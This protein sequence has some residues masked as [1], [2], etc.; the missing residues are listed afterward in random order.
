MVTGHY[1]DNV[2]R[3]LTSSASGTTY[4]S[5]NP[6]LVTVSPEGVLTAVAEG[7]TF[8]T[9]RNQEASSFIVTNLTRNSYALGVSKT[10][11]GTVTST[12][13]G[14][15]CGATCAATFKEGT[16][17]TLTAT[18]AS[19]STFAGWSGACAGTGGCT[20]T[21]DAAK[22][23]TANFNSPPAALTVTKAGTGTG[24][25]TSDPAGI[26]CGATC[27]ATFAA[28][29]NV[30]LAATPASDSTFGGWSG[31][32]C[33]GKS[34]CTVATD[35]AQTVTATFTAPHTLTVSKAGTGAGAI[36]SNPAG[37]IDCG[38]RCSFR[39]TSAL[40]LTLVATPASGSTFAGWSGACSG[41]GDCTVSTATDQSVTATFNT[42]TPGTFALTVNKGGTADGTVTGSGINC[43]ATCVANFASGASV[44]LTATPASG[45]IFSYWTGACSGSNT[46]CTVTMDAAKIV[47]AFFFDPTYRVTLS[48]AGT[49]S[50][51][52]N[53]G[54]S[55]VCNNTCSTTT[56]YGSKGSSFTF[57]ATPASNSTFAGWSGACVGTGNCTVVTDAPKSVTA[58]FEPVSSRYTLTVNITGTGSGTVT[59]GAGVNCN[60]AA[61]T[62]DLGPV[63]GEV[64]FFLS[65]TPASGST[66]AG[67]SGGC[68]GTDKCHVF[69]TV[70]A[71]SVSVT[72][73]FNAGATLPGD[74]NGDN[75]ADALDVVAVINA[76]L[77]LSSLPAADVNGDGT[78]NALDVVYVINK[79]LGL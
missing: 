58:T 18:P 29:T 7:S 12:P 67:W 33:A 50:G 49:G 24:V 10:G 40:T 79:V 48:K 17:V 64:D 36:T 74:V 15:D 35:T 55:V 27:S 22:S 8:V 72:A 59:G 61:C 21:L 43:G 14:I 9:A 62:Y 47:T 54:G 6:E 26:N 38:A 41:T 66:F 25:V 75:R 71:P 57:S 52:V 45:F 56:L 39:T 28:D 46:S 2:D 37:F 3:D 20:V 4:S 16:S 11:A 51:A 69:F 5:A 44:T 34:T 30:T 53:I 1:S 77:G 13:A 78:V 42:T 31:G 60:S 76:V 32:G 23:V 68:S 73:N 70:S 19:G 63:S 65:A